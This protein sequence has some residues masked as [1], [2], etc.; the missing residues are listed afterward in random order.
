MRDVNLKKNK[1]IKRLI[2][3]MKKKHLLTLNKNREK[4]KLSVFFVLFNDKK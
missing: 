3:L 1:E 2:I 4:K